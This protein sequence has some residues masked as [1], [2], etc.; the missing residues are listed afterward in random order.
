MYK[1]FDKDV[2]FVYRYIRNVPRVAFVEAA[3]RAGYQVVAAASDQAEDTV[4][5]FLDAACAKATFKEPRTRGFDRSGRPDGEKVE[6]HD[7]SLSSRLY[8]EYVRWCTENN[9][10]E[11]STIAFGRQMAALGYEVRHTYKGNCYNVRLREPAVSGNA[12]ASPPARL[13]QQKQE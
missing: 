4:R 1:S 8:L 3:R 5:L 2:N 13:D 9:H 10:Y 7:W 11:V 6:S 12:E